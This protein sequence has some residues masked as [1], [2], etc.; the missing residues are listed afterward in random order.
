M[1][2][3]AHPPDAQRQGLAHGRLPLLAAR[4]VQRVQPLLGCR[5]RLGARLGARL[6]HLARAYRSGSRAWR[7]MVRQACPQLSSTTPCPMLLNAE[8]AHPSRSRSVACI[9]CRTGSGV[10]AICRACTAGCA[11]AWRGPRAHAPAPRQSAARLPPPPHRAPRCVRAA[12]RHTSLSQQ[13]CVYEQDK[14]LH[15]RR[16]VDDVYNHTACLKRILS[17]W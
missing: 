8:H 12:P 11:P 14:C 16:R 6:V 4:L 13:E 3:S 5:L 7:F 10:A 9:V 2:A 15:S 1:Q 17:V